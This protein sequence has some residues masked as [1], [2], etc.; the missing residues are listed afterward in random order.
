MDYTNNQLL[1]GSHDGT[2]RVWDCG[3]GQCVFTSEVGGEVDSMLVEHGWLFVGVKTREG[4]GEVKGWA[5]AGGAGGEVRLEGHVGQVTSLAMGNGML[6]SGG[7]VR[8]CFLFLF[9]VSLSC[10]LAVVVGGRTVAVR[11]AASAH[12]MHA[13][14]CARCRIKRSGC[15][16]RL[17]R[18][19]TSLNARR[20]WTSRHRTAIGRRCRR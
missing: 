1:T 14:V 10:C 7:Q 15:G 8:G 5:L 2:V 9:F 17:R 12:T 20:C 3:T 6:F 16:N 13:V 4:R 18:I 11:G 19:R